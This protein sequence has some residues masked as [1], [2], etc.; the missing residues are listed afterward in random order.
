MA[1][2]AR[3]R[4][5]ERSGADDRRDAEH[6][7]FLA[8]ANFRWLKVALALSVASAAGYVMADIEPRPNGGSWYGYTLGSISALLILWLA[9]L[10]IRKRRPTPGSWTL[11]GWTSAH[12]YLG[13]LLLVVG[14]LHTGFQLGYNVH[15]LA[16]VL[17]TLVIA[18]GLY[19]IAVYAILPARLSSNRGEMTRG[20]MVE[21][22]AAID[23]QLESAAQPLA[24]EDADRVI[25]ALGHYPFRAGLWSRL[26]GRD[27]RDPTP[28]ALAHIS[29]ERAWSGQAGAADDN[30]AQQ[31]VRALLGRRQSQI[32]Q[33][34]RHMRLTAL[35]EIW[36]YVHV[37]LTIALIAALIAH[38]VSVFYYW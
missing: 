9:W 10:G 27:R 15:T 24:R 11:K 17:M 38:V 35:L 25:A 37:P 3:R 26:S 36:L 34:R 4:S 1:S 29:T 23:R 20:A 7:S 5:H 28:L 16:W 14:T 32:A 30:P 6:E 31:R 19:G 33:I 18:S 8:H 2:A 12:V 13:L 21:S 22:L